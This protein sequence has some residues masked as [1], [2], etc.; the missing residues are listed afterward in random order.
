MSQSEQPSAVQ[1][2]AHYGDR[3]VRCWPDRPHDLY[4]LLQDSKRRRPDAEAVVCDGERLTY[5]ALKQRVDALATGLSSRGVGTGDR[6]ALFLKNSSTFIVGLFAAARLG[7][8]AVP[9]NVREQTPELLHILNDCA[10]KAVICHS[11]VAGRLP[12]AGEVPALA[13]RIVVGGDDEH[14]LNYEEMCNQAADG[15][16]SPV[17]EEDLACIV[18]TSGTTGRPKGAMLTHLGLVHMAMQY[19]KTMEARSDD[20]MVVAVP[21]SHV[22]GL[23]A[24][25]LVMVRVAGALVLMEE[26]K[27]GPFLEL[28]GAERMTLTTMVPAMYKLCLMRADFAT[29]DLSHW[30]LGA[31]G[32]AMMPVALLEEL[33]AA[34]PG[35]GL[36]NLYGATETSGAVTAMP[37]S[38]T[39]TRPDSVG[40]ALEIADILVM[41][42][43]GREVPVGAAGEVWLRSATTAKGYWNNP[44]ATAREFVAGFWKSG[45]IGTVDEFGYVRIL[46]R[47]K[48]MINRGGYKIYS[49]EV[50]GVLAQHPHILESA[51]VG[52]PCPVLGERV[53][54]FIVPRHEHVDVASLREL[55]VSSLSDYKVPERF[56]IRREP[57][58]RNANGKVLKRQLTVTL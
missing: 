4:A 8:V 33:A 3:V 30:R 16:P 17:S 11:G 44:E 22:T 38:G 28:A 54:A 47:K 24:A 56:I 14:A 55:C 52:A 25:I 39:A 36:L 45:D 15:A 18:Y 12:S 50:E 20:R 13:L 32:G 35:L 53:H 29:A 9:L 43:E 5:A 19:E 31:Y 10:A 1:M 2:E 51:V 40:Q 46:D 49:A 6:I 21:L 42:D 58:P 23:T 27:A 26:F 7:A 37:P 41:D 48:D 57:L 34:L